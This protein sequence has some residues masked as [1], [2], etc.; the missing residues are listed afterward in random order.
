MEAFCAA[1]RAVLGDDA[2]YDELRRL[3]SHYFPHATDL[4]LTFA[5]FVTS[6]SRVYTQA[7]DLRDLERVERVVPYYMRKPDYVAHGCVVPVCIGERDAIQMTLFARE[8]FVASITRF[9][10]ETTDHVEVGDD[11][12]S[13]AR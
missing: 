13:R 8:R 9:D 6:A 3:H 1:A 10:G 11:A 4:K 12:D 5:L 2:P 7:Y